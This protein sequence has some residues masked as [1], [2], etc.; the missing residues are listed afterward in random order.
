[1][2]I[3]ITTSGAPSLETT[4]GEGAQ[5]I[6]APS[7]RMMSDARG[8]FARGGLD[9]GSGILKEERFLPDAGSAVDVQLFAF[10]C[11]RGHCSPESELDMARTRARARKGAYQA[12]V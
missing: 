4:S 8:T 9:I 11:P 5:G 10:C 6:T 12:P 1:M 2:S 3:P 7:L